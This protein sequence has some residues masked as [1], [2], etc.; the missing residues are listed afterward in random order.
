M[1]CK[2]YFRKVWEKNLNA[3]VA[4]ALSTIAI[5]HLYIISIQIAIMSIGIQGV[6][7]PPKSTRPQSLHSSEET[8][9]LQVPAHRT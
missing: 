1:L 4:I 5:T 2:H 6:L 9:H 8:T 7:H 3:V